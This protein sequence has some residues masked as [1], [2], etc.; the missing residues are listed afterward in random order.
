[1]FTKSTLSKQSQ[2]VEPLVAWYSFVMLHGKKSPPTWQFSEAIG[3]LSLSVSFAFYVEYNIFNKKVLWEIMVR[4][5]HIACC[6]WH[7]LD[8]NG[9]LTCFVIFLVSVFLSSGV[10]RVDTLMRVVER[11]L[12]AQIVFTSMPFLM[13]GWRK[14]NPSDGWLDPTVGTG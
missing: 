3:T 8:P 14:L 10:N 9:N 6:L 13:D 4:F 11:A 2:L 1:M 12:S 7:I 5:I